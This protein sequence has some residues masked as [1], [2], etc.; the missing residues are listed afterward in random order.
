[1]QKKKSN[2]INNIL[3]WEERWNN[4]GKAVC[5]WEEATRIHDERRI[6]ITNCDN[7]DIDAKANRQ[8]AVGELPGA[9]SHTEN[10][11]DVIM[12]TRVRLAELMTMVAPQTYQKYVT[13]ERGWKLLYVKWKK[14]YIVCWRVHSYFTKNWEVT[15]NWLDSW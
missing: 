12:F 11:Q 15:C 2:C 10:D 13:A 8:V 7:R 1:M 14:L 3:N 9:F 4:N 5:W 6:C